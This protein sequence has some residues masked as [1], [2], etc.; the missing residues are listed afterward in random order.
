[1]SDLN[2]KKETTKEEF[3]ANEIREFCK[4]VMHPESDL[5]KDAEDWIKER[6]QANGVIVSVCPKCKK[7]NWVMTPNGTFVCMSCSEKWQTEL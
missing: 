7:R 6:L 5:H 4:Y 1:M 3:A 2:E